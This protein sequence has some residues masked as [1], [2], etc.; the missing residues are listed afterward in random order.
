MKPIFLIDCDVKK[1]KGITVSLE[2]THPLGR[3][4]DFDVFDSFGNQI[5]REL[6][7]VDKRT[8]VICNGDTQI[9]RHLNKHPISEVLMKY[10]QIM[11]EYFVNN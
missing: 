4:F 8:C 2:N 10:N 7:G 11:N 1:L 9:C 3:L 6:I 5:K